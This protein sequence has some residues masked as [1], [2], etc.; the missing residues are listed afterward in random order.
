MELERGAGEMVCPGLPHHPGRVTVHLHAGKPIA[1]GRRGGCQHRIGDED[2]S[3]DALDAQHGAQRLGRE[4]M[5]VGDEAGGKPWF[6]QLA[7]Q[8]VLG[9]VHGARQAVAEMCRQGKAGLR[10]FT[11]L[12]DGGVA[13]RHRV[14]NPDLAQRPDGRRRSRPLGAR[15][16]RRIGR[17]SPPTAAD[18]A[19]G[20]IAHRRCRWQ[21]R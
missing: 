2:R 20:P 17:R 10:R 21:P 19:P 7:E 9:L 1:A 5:P 16:T 13:V 14:T 11:D 3:V 8:G 15:V 6:G 4:V 12:A 18:R